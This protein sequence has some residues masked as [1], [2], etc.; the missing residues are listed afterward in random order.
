MIIKSRIHTHVLYIDLTS[1]NISFTTLTIHNQDDTAYVL[2]IYNMYS[3]G[4]TPERVASLTLILNH[5]VTYAY[6]RSC[7]IHATRRSSSIYDQIHNITIPIILRS[8]LAFCEKFDI[9]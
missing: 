8:A 3:F 4:H 6:V 9:I 5:I 7:Y 1:H 2:L